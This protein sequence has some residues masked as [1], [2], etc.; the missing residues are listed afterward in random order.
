MEGITSPGGT[1][2]G[3]GGARERQVEASRR[4]VEGQRYVGGGGGAAWAI[5]LRR[6][7]EDRSRGPQEGA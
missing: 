6:G 2:Q 5:S 4:Q 7:G 3:R 1:G